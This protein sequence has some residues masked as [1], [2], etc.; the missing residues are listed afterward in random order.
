MKKDE[1]EQLNDV[2]TLSGLKEC[3]SSAI[4]KKI[5]Q[6]NNLYEFVSLTAKWIHINLKI[7]LF[8]NM[9]K[10]SFGF[11][12]WLWNFEWRKWQTGIYW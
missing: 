11:R 7:I 10:V 4:M 1:P 12:N 2:Q 8:Q 3:L 5:V 9:S 6:L